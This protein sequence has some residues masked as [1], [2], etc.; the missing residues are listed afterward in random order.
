MCRIYF[1]GP[2]FYV[3]KGFRQNE[4]KICSLY[5]QL[6]YLHL[7]NDVYDEINI[8]VFIFVYIL[9]LHNLCIW[10][11]SP[12]NNVAQLLNTGSSVDVSL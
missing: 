2:L 8:N 11:L 5:V 3:L 12:T 7:V 10:E 9:S 1:C 4:H 6:R